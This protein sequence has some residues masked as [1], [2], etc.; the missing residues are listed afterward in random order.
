MW[1]SATDEKGKRRPSHRGILDRRVDLL[2]EALQFY[3]IHIA[4]EEPFDYTP[5]LHMLSLCCYPFPEPAR[6]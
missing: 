2:D 6:K 5:A 3:R 1:P 4:R